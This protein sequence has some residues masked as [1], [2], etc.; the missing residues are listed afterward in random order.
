MAPTVT[1][2]TVERIYGGHSNFQPTVQV[3]RVSVCSGAVQCSA[4]HHRAIL[5]SCSSS[6]MLC[7][8]VHE[9][10]RCWT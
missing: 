10:R 2:Q 1:P 5:A 4:Q 3:S 7:L 6:R 9:N 8:C